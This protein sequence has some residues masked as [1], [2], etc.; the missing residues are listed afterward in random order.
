MQR[1]FLNKTIV[2]DSFCQVQKI[3]YQLM[4]FGWVVLQIV[5]LK[6]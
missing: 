6:N 1:I 3:K 5:K 4:F 2:L